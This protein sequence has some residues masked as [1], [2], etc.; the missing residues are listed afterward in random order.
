M[1]AV[2]TGGA[3]FIGSHL[4]DALLAAGWHVVVVDDLSSG[5]LNNLTEASST[6]RLDIMVADICGPDWVVH[7]GVDLVVNLACAGSPDRFAD[8]PLEILAA[9]S[10]GMRRV[11]DL[12]LHTGARLIQASTSEV[13]GDALV[14]P[15]PE[16]YWGNVNPIGPRSVYDESK[17]FA[18]AL[19][20]AHVRLGEL[21]AGIV[22]V[23]NTY[24]PRLQANDGRVVPTF[25]RQAMANMPLTVY[26]AGNQTRSYCYIDD[27]VRGMLTFAGCRGELGPL[28]LGNPN[29]ITV[30]RLAKL[31]SELIG[32]PLRVKHEE[33]PQD[34]PVRRCPDITLASQL[35]G[36]RPVVSL[37][38]GLT[39]TIEW[40]YSLPLA[41]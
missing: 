7:G 4:V 32:C 6:G 8:R 19:I 41:A 30:L 17:R 10:T 28:N 38:D 31:I 13:Y 33:L 37:H 25:I 1:R 14:H 24:G 34:D 36:W 3:G 23:F 21:D 12:A 20:A 5:Y 2:V 22:R 15:Q 29:E 39:R 11:I 16:R 18:E 26:G 35:L 27:L 9:G 40:F